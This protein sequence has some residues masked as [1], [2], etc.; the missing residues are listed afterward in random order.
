MSIPFPHTQKSSPATVDLRLVCV[1]R[2]T[3]NPS[4]TQ[5]GGHTSAYTLLIDGR[6]SRRYSLDNWT[7]LADGVSL[8]L[9]KHILHPEFRQTVKLSLAACPDCLFGCRGLALMM[10]CQKVNGTQWKRRWFWERN[11]ESPYSR[12]HVWDIKAIQLPA[13]IHIFISLFALKSTFFTVPTGVIG[14]YKLGGFFLKNLI[15]Q[16]WF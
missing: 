3:P 12:M 4:R 13:T 6:S 1:H 16:V 7:P 2:G 11:R 8:G 10:K 14:C 5:T 15:C 9:W